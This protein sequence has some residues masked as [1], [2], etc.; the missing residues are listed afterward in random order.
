MMQRRRVSVVVGLL[1]SALTYF[2]FAE[3]PVGSQPVTAAVSDVPQDSGGGS[4]EASPNSRNG[5][6]ITAGAVWRGGMKVKSS[7][8]GNPA[9]V[10]NPNE[11]ANRTY[12]DGYVNQDPG[13]GNPLSPDPNTTW[14]WGYDNASQYDAGAEA[15]SFHKGGK[16]DEDMSGYGFEIA[17][18]V[19][20]IEMK[21]EKKFG[22]DLCMGF[23][24]I[25][26]DAETQDITDIYDTT[27]AAIPGA[28]HRG[29]YNGPFDV[30]PASGTLI[31][32]QPTGRITTPLKVDT[33]IY[34]LW[35]GPQLFYK[36]CDR[37]S[38]HL[39]PKISAN[40]ISVDV[41][42][43]AGYSEGSEGEFLPG[44]GLVGGLDVD[45]TDNLFLR[46]WGG[47]EWV[48][49]EVDVRLQPAGTVS[50]DVSGY[51]AGAS[52]GIRF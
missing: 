47:Y 49:N 8:A 13:T 12:D 15:L 48:S 32:N 11:Y 39:T 42:R 1:L 14:F 50:V 6:W 34:E 10:G 27:G 26:A 21:D 45:L 30:P 40:Y 19:P 31:P 3:E 4:V 7:G 9:S 43:S 33:E 16:L 2:A 24:M 44:A 28:P 46:V 23:Q 36:P 20:V 29:T 41:N 17:F 37:I 51:T 25:F 18:G 38:L 52:I 35:M 22:M 5:V